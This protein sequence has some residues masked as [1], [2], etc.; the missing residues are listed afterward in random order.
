MTCVTHPEAA[1]VAFCRTCGK[2]LCHACRQEVVGVIYCETCAAAQRVAIPP[3]VQ[4]P[5]RPASAPDAPSPGLAFVLGLIPGVGAIYNGQYGKGIVHVVVLGLLISIVSSDAAGDLEPMF[6]MLIPVWCFYMA[7][8]AYHTAK[9][10]AAGLV[11]DEF[12]GLLKVQG[13]PGRVPLGPIVL[14]LLGVAFLLNSLGIWRLHQVVRF[15]PV[16]L[17]LAG[18]YM[19]FAR[20]TGRTPTPGGGGGAGQADEQAGMPFPPGGGQ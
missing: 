12:S 1:A 10:R 7:L 6:G 5:T 2:A 17:I 8:E 11:V 3:P 19:L 4:A 15:W 18:V 14:I 13:G 9:K 20:L 16:L